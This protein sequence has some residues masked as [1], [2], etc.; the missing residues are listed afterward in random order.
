VLALRAQDLPNRVEQELDRVAD[1]ALAELA[2]VREV[3]ANLGR[4]DV[5]VLGDLLGGDPRL[6][7]LPRLRQHLEVPGQTGGDADVQ[8][9]GHATPLRL[10]RLPD[11]LVCSSSRPSR[12]LVQP[13]D[14]AHPGARST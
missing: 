14:A 13:H 2:E 11:G 8:A 6:A 5:R 7:H 4:V 1:S 10:A 9:L 3:T 12:S